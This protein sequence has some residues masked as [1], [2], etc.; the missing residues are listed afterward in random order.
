MCATTA[1]RTASA[2]PRRGFCPAHVVLLLVVPALLL[3]LPWGLLL[4]PLLL[5]AV[6]LLRLLAV[7]LLLWTA[8]LRLTMPLRA[9]LRCVRTT[10]TEWLQQLAHALL[11]FTNK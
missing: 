2:M 3:L 10:A 4:Q 6:L 8:L 1:A 11:R 9:L 7:L 5:W